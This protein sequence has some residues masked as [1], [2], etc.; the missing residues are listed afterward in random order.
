MKMVSLGTVNAV[1][2]STPYSAGLNPF[3]PSA[4]ATVM[5]ACDAFNGTVKVQTSSDGTSYTDVATI[6]ETGTDRTHMVA[7][8]DCKEYVR[9]NCTVRTAGEA[10]GFLLG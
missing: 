1:E 8:T 9:L 7:L 6:T 5:V 10:E 4:E 3:Y 2:T